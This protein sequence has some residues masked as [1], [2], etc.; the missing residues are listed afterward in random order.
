MEAIGTI[1]YSL[2]MIGIMAFFFVVWF[3]LLKG[4]QSIASTLKEI[5]E[6]LKSKPPH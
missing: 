6:T 5:S 2:T 1:I 3:K 4:I